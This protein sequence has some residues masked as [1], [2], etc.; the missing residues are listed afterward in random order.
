LREL[1]AQDVR[2]GHCQLL[3]EAQVPGMVRIQIARD[4][5]MADVAAAAL[6]AAAPQQTVLLLAGAQ[7]AARDRGVP[8]H[9]AATDPSWP[10][11]VVMFG[12]LSAGLAADEHRKA[13]LTPQADHCED[14]RRSLGSR[15][16]ASAPR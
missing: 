3:P 4:R 1:L 15:S 6:R 8:L 2:D 5:S 7:H 9:L 12:E 14:L 10:V 16:A 13:E 11:R